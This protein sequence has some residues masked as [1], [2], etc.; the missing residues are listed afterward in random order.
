M[1]KYFKHTVVA[2]AT[3]GRPVYLARCLRSLSDLETPLKCKTT[4]VVVDN[5]PGQD[6][7]E[8]VRSFRRDGTSHLVYLHQPQRG[9]V[10]A[11]NCALNYAI[12]QSATHLAFIDDDEVV[13]PNWLVALHEALD[14][15]GCSIGIGPVSR[16]FEAE[17]STELKSA[18]PFVHEYQGL[19]FPCR[20]LPATNNVLMRLDPVVRN[21]VRFDIRYSLSGGSDSKFFEELLVKGEKVAWSEDARVFE[22]VPATRSNLRWVVK[23]C[24]RYGLNLSRC[25]LDRHV[26]P[27]A[28]LRTVPHAAGNSTLCIITIL[29][30]AFRTRRFTVD[31]ICRLSISLGA[32]AFYLGFGSEEYRQVHGQ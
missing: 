32:I 16:V 27:S 19:P 15:Y 29:I 6:A 23:R 8:L 20:K 25:T 7:K 30:S 3:Y 12:A 28:L 9:I 13:R 2:V 11:R 24:F 22:Y 21:N 1:P 18:I 26:L 5:N 17:T 31:A 4:L 14:R 10:P